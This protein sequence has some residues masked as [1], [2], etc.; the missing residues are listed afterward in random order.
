MTR[1]R[2]VNPGFEDLCNGDEAPRLCEGWS[3]EFSGPAEHTRYCMTSTGEGKERRAKLQ[4]GEVERWFRLVQPIEPLAAAA[5]VRCSLTCGQNGEIQEATLARLGIIVREKSGFLRPHVDIVTHVPLPGLPETLDFVRPMDAMDETLAYALVIEFHTP[6]DLDVW[7]VSLDYFCANGLLLEGAPTTLADEPTAVVEAGADGP[8]PTVEPATSVARTYTGFIDDVDAGAVSGWA[9]SCDDKALVFD[10]VVHVDGLPFG[11]TRNDLPRDDLAHKGRSAGRGG[12]RLALPNGFGDGLS[13][14]ISIELPDGSFAKPRSMSPAAPGRIACLP[15]LSTTGSCSPDAIAVIV[16]VY[17]AFEDL[18]ECVD[19]LQANSPADT[20]FIFVDDCSTDERVAPFLRALAG[21]E[22]RVDVLRN[23]TNR[24]FSGTVNRGV[25]AAGS[26][27]VILLNS[28]ARVTPG[29][30]DGL[31]A[32]ARS[33]PRVSTVTPLSDNAGAFS[34]PDMGRRNRMPVGIDERDLAVAV[35]RRSDCLYP[36]VPTGN[37]FCMFVSRACIDDIGVFD[38]DAFPRGYGEENDFCLRARRAGWTHLMDDATYVFHE[39]SASFGNEKTGLM[40]QGREIVDGRYPEYSTLTPLFRSATM[41]MARY[42]V[43]Q[44]IEDARLAPRVLP[45]ALYVYSTQSGGTPQT[46]RDLMAQMVDRLET[47][48]LRCN[49]Q[50]LFLERFDGQQSVAVET[51]RLAEPINPVDH[52]SAEYDLIVRDWLVRH[53]IALVHVRHLGWHGLGLPETASELDIPVVLSFHDFYSVCPSVNLLDENNQYCGGRC[54]K[55]PGECANPL[56]P[57]N[58][59]PPLKHGWVHRWREL[60]AQVFPHCSAFI[61][62]SDSA[63]SVIEQAFPMLDGR[64]R[65]IPHGRTVSMVGAAYTPPSGTG[66]IR[67]LV[68]G[69]IG[70]SKGIG[71]IHALLDLDGGRS[72]EFHVLGTIRAEDVRPGIV[73]H[74]GYQRDE[75]AAN[76]NRIA[77]TAAAV[78]SIWDETWC[79]TLTE[80]WAAGVP[81]IVFEYG[82]LASRVRECGGGWVLSHA[83]PSALRRGIIDAVEDVD[84]YARKREAVARWQR[85]TG[86][87]LN[88]SNMASR[89]FDVYRSLLGDPV[90]PTDPTLVPRLE[91][92][93]DTRVA[94]VCPAS[95]CLQKAP[96]STQ[97]RIWA[98]TRSSLSSRFNYFRCTAAQFVAGVSRGEIER[99]IVQRNVIPSRLMAPVLEAMK[100]GRLQVLYDIDDDLLDVPAEKDPDG[101]YSENAP[102]LRQLIEQADVVTVS[103]PG[104]M[105]RM[106]SLSQRVELLPNLLDEVIWHTANPLRFQRDPRKVVAMYMGSRTHDEDIGF[107]LPAFLAACRSVP[108][109]HL[110]IV[111]GFAEVPEDLSERIEIIPV[112]ARSRSYPDFVRLLERVSIDVD[113]ALGPLVDTPF[114]A[115]KSELKIL[116]YAG[117]GLSGLYSNCDVYRSMTRELGVGRLV[118][119]TVDSWT[120]AIVTAALEK[121]KMHADGLLAR[122]RVMTEYTIAGASD[123]FESLV[124]SLSGPESVLPAPLV[125]CEPVKEG[126]LVNGE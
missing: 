108:N 18:R 59:L 36:E 39:R 52:R 34:A 22:P 102:A 101:G 10:V 9:V 98:R 31:R 47:W 121:E 123:R 42:R 46:N 61:T 107:M 48:T 74:G 37:G 89:Y 16:P 45:R 116:E 122:E 6:V 50:T 124:G 58:S 40:A 63:R 29:W 67:L 15:R 2:L 91:A 60:Q 81:T 104:L 11:S 126:S 120:E 12:F 105:S 57:S 65:V 26:A 43:R 106:A 41:N 114:N 3:A 109:L 17:N 82:T 62:T 13:H 14:D 8:S 69:N 80:M 79:H 70:I 97:I 4:I 27:D 38:A 24:G 103:T 100:E 111:S 1:T 110:R 117:L 32:A 49:R 55:T 72:L 23:P 118:A 113:F 35:R 53:D 115:C 44:A 77:P 64:I 71:V 99:A 112:P 51:H 33:R 54:S 88:S 68:P 5:S 30:I 76:I 86:H 20:S 119:E 84:G 90:R 95:D 25:E 96:A 125:S 56:W 94:V 66:R 78:F 75:I 73:C 7:D 93:F 87:A 19:R 28:D 21:D 83:E 92:G 85:T